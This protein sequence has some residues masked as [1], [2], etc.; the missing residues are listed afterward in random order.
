MNRNKNG[1]RQDVRIDAKS[2]LHAYMKSSLYN[3]VSGIKI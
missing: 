1:K 3:P 2:E